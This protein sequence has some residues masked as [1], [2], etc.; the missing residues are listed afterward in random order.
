MRFILARLEAAGLEPAPEADRATLI[1]RAMFDVWGLP[2]D[3]AEVQ[4]FVADP[5]PAGL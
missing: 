1:R 4:A 5:D 2:P 3:P